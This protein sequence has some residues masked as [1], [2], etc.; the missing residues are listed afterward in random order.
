MSITVIRSETIMAGEKGILFQ[1][2]TTFSPRFAA[3][4][5]SYEIFPSKRTRLINESTYSYEEG[6]IKEFEEAISIPRK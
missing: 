2:T 3:T 6:A 5:Q 4:F 1:V